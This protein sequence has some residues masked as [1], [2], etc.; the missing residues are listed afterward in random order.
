[1]ETMELNMKD[2]AE[3]DQIASGA[4]VTGQ[5]NNVWRKLA[6]G[7]FMANIGELDSSSCMTGRWMQRLQRQ[8]EKLEERKK[9]RTAK[10]PV[11]RTVVWR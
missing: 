8:V 10:R 7:F 1:M 9:I 6:R 4:A 3:P 5:M 2:V 11:I